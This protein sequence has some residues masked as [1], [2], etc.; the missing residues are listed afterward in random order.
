MPD[1]D[2]FALARDALA[3]ARS[4]NIMIVTAE[5]CTGGLIAAAL[6]HHAGSSDVVC[7]GFV[8]YSNA[9]KETLLGVERATLERFGAVSEPVARAMSAGALEKAPGAGVAIAV[10]GIAGPGGGS[11]GK[12]VGLV[13][14]SVSRTRDG[15]TTTHSE[16]RIF[17]GDRTAVRTATVAHA[18]SLVIDAMRA[19]P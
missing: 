7:G 11:A 13:W 14:F 9:M 17:P 2:C 6:T 8:T 1:P 10:T 16:H 5:S 12:P 4:E 15:A 18:L 19:A 3:R